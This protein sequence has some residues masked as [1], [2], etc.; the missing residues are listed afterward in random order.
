MQD[1]LFLNCGANNPRNSEGGFLGL[2]NGR[3]LFVY[4]RYTGDSWNDH[5]AADLAMRESFDGGRTWTATDRILFEHGAARNLM[6]VSLLRLTSGRIMLY[7]CRKSDGANGS[8]NCVPF[9]AWSDDEARHWSPLH[10][11]WKTEGFYVLNNDRVIQLRDGRI[12]LPLADDHGGAL[13]LYS[14]DD[15]ETWRE[16]PVLDIARTGSASGLQEPGVLELA[17]GRIWSWMRTDTGCQ[18]G[19][20]SA[21]RG[22]SW[23]TPQPLPGFL[24]PLSPMS[25]RR[26]PV[27]GRLV[28][29]WNDL[30]PRWGFPAPVYTSPGWVDSPTGGRTPLALA[31]SSDE[32]RSW[33]GHRLLETDR[34]RGFCYTAMF[35]TGDALLL[36]Y[37]CGGRN[38]TIMLQNLKIRRLECDSTGELE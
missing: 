28:A 24:S 14:D 22:E 26:N 19:T 31:A 11:V 13:F 9:C 32:G 15:G 2:P 33:H 30:S 37:C 4:S 8:L 7:C 29:V 36:A 16:S 27:N 10:P 6:S 35:F 23:Q 1:V 25:V 12:I 18:Y 34:E 20:F 5:A 21:D 38:G 17:D 3:I